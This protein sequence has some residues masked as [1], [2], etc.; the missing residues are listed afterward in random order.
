MVCYT[1]GTA[2]MVKMG[3]GQP[4]VPDPPAKLFGFRGNLLSIPGRV[5]HCRFSGLGV[6]Y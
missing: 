5:D 1:G 3:V 4:D 6:G 2:K